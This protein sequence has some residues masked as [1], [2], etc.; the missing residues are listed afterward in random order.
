[1]FLTPKF[2]KRDDRNFGFSVPRRARFGY[3]HGWESTYPGGGYRAKLGLGD[4]QGR[5]RHV[6]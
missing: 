4:I 6:R 3:D 2:P 1:M 5:D